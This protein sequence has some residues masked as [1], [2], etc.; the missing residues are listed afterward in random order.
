MSDDQSDTP[1]LG[2]QPNAGAVMAAKGTFIHTSL[3][4]CWRA[5]SDGMVLR[6]DSRAFAARVAKITG[7]GRGKRGFAATLHEV[8]DYAE[9]HHT[10]ARG[11]TCAAFDEQQ[12]VLLV[13]IG[14][15]CT[16]SIPRAGIVDRQ[17]NFVAGVLFTDEQPFRELPWDDL[18]AA[19]RDEWWKFSAFH[20]A[21]LNDLPPSPDGSLAPAEQRALMLAAWVSIFLRDLAPERPIPVPVG[22]RGTAKT[23]TACLFG[24]A[25]YGKGYNVSGG[26]AVS[27]IVKDVAA[28]VSSR[29]FVARDD[30]NDAPDGLMDLLCRC[31]TGANIELS[32]FHE[33]LALSTFESKAALMLTAN[34]PKWAERPD[35]LSRLLVFRFAKPPPDEIGKKARIQRVLDL[36][37]AI[38]TE[39]LLALQVVLQD[40]PRRE[41]ITRF[42]DWEH[43]VR[44]VLDQAGMGEAFESALRKQSAERVA[45]VVA[46]NPYLGLLHAFASSDDVSEQWFTAAELIDALAKF[47]GVEDHR[48]DHH[49]ALYAI[50]NP[51]AL[52]KTLAHLEGAGS[53]VV[54]VN[55]SVQKAH[56]NMLR[57]NIKPVS[58]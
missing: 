46:A 28:A 24:T 57:W 5:N 39:T 1:T 51:R 52:S 6:Q 18:L 48:H 50:R 32:S 43:A 55:R 37:P 21:I 2:G 41:P 27:R 20:D 31:A 53:A 35:V 29:A 30:L 58:L 10:K 14:G 44:A 54:D 11:E 16:I 42:A 45:I 56:G 13:N 40:R 36:R 19:R 25:F 38:W 15:R 26:A 8:K 22:P 49:R 47:S 33:T 23:A 4:R 9:S 34:R 3:G 12:K 7:V 17:T